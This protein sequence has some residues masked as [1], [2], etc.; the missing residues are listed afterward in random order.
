MADVSYTTS[1]S[2]TAGISSNQIVVTRG[3]G[4]AGAGAVVVHLDDSLSPAEALRL[5]RA[6]GRLIRQDISK[7]TGGTVDDIPTTGAATI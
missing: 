5:Y 6:V 4:T 1:K 2:A 7:I 3:V